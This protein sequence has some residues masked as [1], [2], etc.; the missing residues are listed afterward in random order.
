MP[1]PRE[2]EDFGVFNIERSIPGLYFPHIHIAP[3]DWVLS[4]GVYTRH[5]SIAIPV[6]I[7]NRW[8]WLSEEFTVIGWVKKKV[9]DVIP[10]SPPCLCL[11]G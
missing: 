2:I 1:I 6:N 7:W 9:G 10:A 11:R 8:A 5:V 3:G 4:G